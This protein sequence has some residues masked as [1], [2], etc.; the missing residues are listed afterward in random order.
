MRIRNVAPQKDELQDTEEQLTPALHEG[1]VFILTALVIIFFGLVI[2]YSTSFITTG[3]S[4]FA[5]QMLW[6][7]IGT[8]GFFAVIL[9]GYQRLCQW[10][11][12]FLGLTSLLL[13]AT[14]FSDPINGARR[15]L[16]IGPFSLQ[17]AEFAKVALVLFLSKFL[18]ERIRFL[19]SRNW[20]KHWSKIFLPGAVI[21][22]IP[23]G[24]VLLG[25]DLGT[26][27]LLGT[28]FLAMMFVAG[29]HW[30][31]W[32]LPPVLIMPCLYLGITLFS[33]V[34]LARITSFMDPEK[35]QATI[36]YQL[37]HSQLALG[38]GKWFGVGFAESRLK[39]KYLP[40]AHTDFILSIAGEELGFIAVLLVIAAYLILMFAGIRISQKSRTLQGMFVAYGMIIFITIQAVINLGVVCGAFPTKGMPAPMISY[41]GSNLLACMIAAGCV[42]SVALDTAYP[43][44]DLTVQQKLQHYL[45]FLKRQKKA[46]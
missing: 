3:I 11:F 6:M 4:F 39:L 10:S 42:F 9:V 35:Y 19:R 34:R 22:A 5:K 24:L 37:W 43:D 14:L 16:R 41:G 2:L 29:I 12:V 26:T 30:T 28:V 17:S 20:K 44:Y 7:S 45:P 18:S 36:G 32:L 40:E 31:C 8:L 46:G 1:A 21:C 23:I 33:P 13:I 25:K 15:W 27:M 38:S